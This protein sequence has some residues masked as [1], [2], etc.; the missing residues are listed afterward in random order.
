MPRPLS[1]SWQYFELVSPDNGRNKKA[2]CSFCGH[3]QA[4]G[5]TRLHQHLL[6]R[7]SRISSEIRDQLRQKQDERESETLPLQKRND[8]LPLQTSSTANYQFDPA[9]QNNL[10]PSPTTALNPHSNYFDATLSP[11]T[12]TSFSTPI[13]LA[14]TSNIDNLNQKKQQQQQQQL[15][16]SQAMLDWHL[17]RALFSANIPYDKIEDPHIIEFFKRLQPSYVVPKAK[18]LQQ[19]LLKEQHWDLIPCNESDTTHQIPSPLTPNTSQQHAMLRQPQTN[20][21]MELSA[22][23]H[24]VPTNTG[25]NAMSDR[26]FS[27]AD[28]EKNL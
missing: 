2:K 20:E 7:C 19:F 15:D 12:P 1:D 16:G 10:D 21:H 6:Y 28:L 14:F 3:A 23:S 26:L 25:S 18:R 13:P 22:C 11:M 4:A 24:T 27:P 8:I 5:I 17:A 9:L